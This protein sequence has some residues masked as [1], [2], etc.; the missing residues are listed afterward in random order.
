MGGE[1]TFLVVVLKA[2]TE[3]ALMLL[4]AQFVLALFAGRRRSE[5]FVYRIFEIATQPVVRFTRAITP[6]AI[7]DQHLPFVSFLLLLVL[8]IALTLGKIY[9]VR[10]AP[11]LGG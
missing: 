4:V 6:R 9:L 11:G 2:V 3:I 5:N 8:W 10:V 7:L 1:V